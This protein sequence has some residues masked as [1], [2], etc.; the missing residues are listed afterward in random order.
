MGGRART[1]RGEAS[2][3]LGGS[4][5]AKVRHYFAIDLDEDVPQE[6]VESYYT[7]VRNIARVMF[8]VG[9]LHTERGVIRES[10]RR[11]EPVG[12]SVGGDPWWDM[13]ILHLNNDDSGG[14]GETV[15]RDPVLHHHRLRPPAG[16]GVTGVVLGPTGAE[17]GSDR[18]TGPPG[19]PQED[20]E[21]IK[22]TGLH[23]GRRRRLL[24][25]LK[26]V[27]RRGARSTR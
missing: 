24:Q 9:E 8:G 3:C 20:T 27:R 10:V 23:R 25:A 11:V 1:A 26:Q 15:V 6:L 13:P 17:S 4:V 2:R 21:E 18:L 12:N 5:K 22:M 7:G 16:S 14:K 19:G